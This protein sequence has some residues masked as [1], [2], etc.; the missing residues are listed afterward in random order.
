MGTGIMYGAW[1]LAEEGIL[2]GGGPSKPGKRQARFPTEQPYSVDVGRL[3]QKVGI[4]ADPYQ[5][6]FSR[7]EPFAMV[8]GMAADAHDLWLEG[9][10]M[11]STEMLG[12]ALT[13]FSKN[14]ASK[15]FMKGIAEWTGLVMHPDRYAS[16]WTESMARSMVPASALMGQT[17]RWMDPTRREV[18][19]VKEAVMSQIPGLRSQLAPGR[20]V[21]GEVAPME[22]AGPSII[23]P[24]Y[25]QTPSDDPVAIEPATLSREVEDFQM[26]KPK[27]KASDGTRYTAEEYQ[28]LW[29]NA[30]QRAADR[31]RSRVSSPGWQN[32]SFERRAERVKKIYNRERKRAREKIRRMRRMA[33]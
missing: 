12:K 32:L 27:K 11:E 9:D 30:N 1:E 17:A 24:F 23:S 25:A 2:T 26:G 29:G 16:R 4:D 6:S 3:L 20:S 33:Q 14:L 19:S 7:L 10:T 18:D 22:A 31:L 21:T 28:E 8:I 15:T 5:I 13:I